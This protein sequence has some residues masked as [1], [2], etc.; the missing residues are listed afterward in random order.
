MNKSESHIQAVIL[1]LLAVIMCCTLLI[2]STFAWFTDTVTSS[3]NKIESG[4]LIVDLE[5]LSRDGTWSSIKNDQTPLFANAVWEPGYT[6]VRIIK[7]ENEGDLTLK[8]QAKFVM[9]G[10]SSTLADVIDVYTLDFGIIG[11]NDT[12]AYPADRNLIGY[13]KVG[14]LSE[15]MDAFS[16]ENCGVLGEGQAQCLGIALKMQ[17]SAGNEYQ[18]LTLGRSFDIKIL[19]T[20]TSDEVDVFGDD[21]DD[22]ASFP[23]LIDSAASLKEAMLVRGAN[24][25]LESDIVIDASVPLQYGSYMF[26]ANGREVT[27][28]LNGHDLIIDAS[29][30][31]KL[32]FLFTTANGGTL[33]IVGEGNLISENGYSGLCWAMNKG[34][35]INIYGGNFS[36]ESLTSAANA[37]IY[38]TSGSID[39]YGGR[40]CKSGDLC[41]NVANSQGNRVCIVFHEGVIFAT[42]TIQSGDSARIK[43]TDG[44]MLQEV[45]DNGEIWYQV[46]KE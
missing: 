4:D 19:A 5:L 22:S 20:Q 41:A 34:D 1:S 33:N 17:E 12:V 3:G 39:V 24:I 35:Q 16:D 2:G 27:I 40:F 32:E 29:V 13:T 38:T 11:E 45:E 8:W 6:D 9:V 44:C 36:S 46:V 7:I 18:G 15:Y 26:L 23:V 42:N 14:T 43:L 10:A 28:N 30:S 37:L 31:K 21:Y 25:V